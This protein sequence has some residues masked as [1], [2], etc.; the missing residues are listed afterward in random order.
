MSGT[1][2]LAGTLFP[3]DPLTKR[4]R[5]QREATQGPGG[6]VYADLWRFEANFGTLKTKAESDY[7]LTKFLAGGL[8]TTV[9]PHP[10]TGNL[11]TFTGAA[12]EDYTFSFGDVDS[13]DYALNP[14]L[15]LGGININSAWWNSSWSKR[16]QIEI[17]TGNDALVNGYTVR[18]YITGS[19]ASAIYNDSLASGDDVRLL[20]RDSTEVDR[21][22]TVFTAAEIEMMFPLQAAL[23]PT[24]YNV[25]YRLYY[26]NAAAG[27]PAEDKS[28][29]YQ[30]YDGFESYSNGDLNG[31]GSW[32]GATDFQVQSTTVAVGSKAVH[33]PGTVANGISKS[34]A[35][36][37][38]FRISWR[39]RREDT[40]SGRRP[41]IQVFEGATRIQFVFF[42]SNTLNID[43]VYYFPGSVTD[44]GANFVAATWH[45]VEMVLKPTNKIDVWFD[46]VKYVTDGDLEN[47]MVNGCDTITPQVFSAVTTKEGWWD[48]ITVRHLVND[49]PDVGIIE[50]VETR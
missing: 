17:T 47:N 5:R 38:H 40:S 6:G 13:D 20:Y 50:V 21:D 34:M 42:G 39:M 15:T 16:Q 10:Q 49:R 4:W 44:T 3:K 30:F 27:S 48:E 19:A 23:T 14:R 7:F 1:F 9:L 22:L 46:R 2:Q 24:T 45:Q 25:D 31:Q 8:Y 37:N 36:S 11:A 12:I 35:Q 28:N 29:V 33:H 32:S 41:T 43:T 18:L 26:D